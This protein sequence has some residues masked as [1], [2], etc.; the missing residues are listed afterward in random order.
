[1][2]RGAHAC[3]IRLLASFL[4]LIPALVGLGLHALLAI[5]LYRVTNRYNLNGWR[6][7]CKISF[8]VITVQLQWCDVCAL[9]LDLYVAFPLSLTGHQYMGD[10]MALYYAPLFFEG[11]AFNALFLLLF[12][13]SL[14]RFLIFVFPRVNHRVF[15]YM[16]TRMY[17]TT[18]VIL[19]SVIKEIQRTSTHYWTS[20]CYFCVYCSECR[21]SFGLL[22]SYLLDYQ[23]TSD[24]ES[25]LP[26]MFMSIA[27]NIFPVTMIVMY[28][29]VYV[30]IRNVTRDVVRM[31]F[32]RAKQEVKYF[33]QTV[34]IS[35]L[36]I[37]E[38]GAFVIVPYLGVTGY[39]QFYLNILMNLIIIS[40]NLVTPAVIFTFNS[41]VR[42][43]LLSLISREPTQ[44]VQ[45]VTTIL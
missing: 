6:N 27:S 38:M 24:V 3:E 13:M 23:I 28:V 34:L 4:I 45:V 10:S 25:S 18:L 31:D 12:L 22:Y 14:N 8:Y 32:S 40:T 16:G 15:T 33:V 7:F 1:M 19:N 41:D 17:V 29:I 42:Q 21:Y 35:I 11:I 2:A 39:G 9:F 30:K 43:S 37:V 36:I 26:K 20:C 44:T 5:T